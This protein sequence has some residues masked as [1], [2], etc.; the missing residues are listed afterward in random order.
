MPSPLEIVFIVLGIALPLA[1]G[2]TLVDKTGYNRW[3]GLLVVVPLANIG[4]LFFLLASTWP[5][6]RELALR[7]LQAGEGTKVD[8]M[9]AYREA[10]RLQKKGRHPEAVRIFGMIEAR[11][12]GSEIARD[13]AISRYE[14]ERK[15]A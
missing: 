15:K 9:T 13:S 14:S 11:L 1:V 10:M 2:V 6:H 8:G 12:A 3:I 5:I 4:L 7:R